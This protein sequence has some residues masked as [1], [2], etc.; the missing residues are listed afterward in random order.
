VEYTLSL[1]SDSKIKNGETKY[2]LRESM[3][4]I[5]PEKIRKRNDKIGFETPQDKWFRLDQFKNLI[6]E[7]LNSK[8]FNNRKYINADKAKKLY[9]KHLAGEI[10]ISRDIW[11]WINL[12]LW[13]RKYMD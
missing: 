6:N 10:N 5:L 4:G 12:E 2:V 3:K 11:K 7:I 8:S 9:E 1:P 13:F